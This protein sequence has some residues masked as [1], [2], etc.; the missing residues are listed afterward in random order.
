VLNFV[1]IPAVL[2]LLPL[3]LLLL[4][5]LLTVAGFDDLVD[6][7]SISTLFAFWIVALALIWNRYF[8]PGVSPRP[9]NLKVAAHLAVIV[10]ASVGEWAS[11]GVV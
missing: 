5:L 7:V 1:P 4:L 3:L 10:A 11:W 2:L 8:K 6:M 9:A